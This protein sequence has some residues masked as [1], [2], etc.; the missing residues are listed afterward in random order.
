MLQNRSTSPFDR[1]FFK[2]FEAD[3]FLDEVM[4]F[5]RERRMCVC[6]KAHYDVEV[7]DASFGSKSIVCSLL[8]SFH[9]TKLPGTLDKVSQQRTSTRGAKKHI[10]ERVSW[11]FFGECFQQFI[12]VHSIETNTA[13]AL[14]TCH[15]LRVFSNFLFIRACPIWCV[16]FQSLDV[17]LVR[18]RNHFWHVCWGVN[19]SVQAAV[20]AGKGSNRPTVPRANV[21]SRKEVNKKII[22]VTRA[23]FFMKISMKAA[24]T[25][26]QPASYDSNFQRWEKL[27]L[28]R[29]W[30]LLIAFFKSYLILMIINCERENNKY[31]KPFLYGGV[32]GK[33]EG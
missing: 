20:E 9:C 8:P 24:P 28:W 17:Y 19:F 33:M 25:R 21:N 30:K 5:Y 15:Q 22:N 6:T 12:A 10:V 11:G 13:A 1:L 18:Q 4:N 32:R 29:R 16:H 31:L 23:S 26:T 7:M 14:L 3:E 2:S 27:Y